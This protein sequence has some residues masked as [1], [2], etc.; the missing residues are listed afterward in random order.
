[1]SRL[2]HT[3]RAILNLAGVDPTALAN[4]VRKLPPVRTLQDR[5]TALRLVDPAYRKRTLETIVAAQNPEIEQPKKPGVLRIATIWEG[6]GRFGWLDHANKDSDCELIH[7]PRSFVNPAWRLFLSEYLEESREEMRLGEY[8]LERYFKAAFLEPRQKFR[9]YCALAMTEAIDAYELDC[10]IMPKLTDD[11]TI[12]FINAVQQVG[13]PVV[14][15]DREGGVSPK[16]LEMVPAHLRALMEVEFDLL[17]THNEIQRELFL[18]SGLPANKILV[19]GA[20][21]SDYWFRPETW[22]TRAEIHPQLRDDRFTIVFFSFGPRTYMNFY[23]GT[24]TRDWN[25]LCRDYHDV[26]LDVLRQYGDRVQIIYKFGGKPARDLFEGY[27]D[28][29]ARAENYITPDNFI[30]LDGTFNSLDLIRNADLILGFQTTGLIEAMFTDNPVVY[31]AWGPLFDDIHE[32]LLPLDQDE[33]LIYA[34]SKEALAQS[35]H[36]LIESPDSFVCTDTMRTARVALRERYFARADGQVSRRL[37]DHAKDI[38]QR[39]RT[40][41]STSSDNRILSVDT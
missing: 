34:N 23:Y 2:K 18:R 21:Q 9:D 7:L 8:A 35:M 28:F 38:A 37:L 6:S 19:N 39:R 15:D 3:A 33:A 24:E 30:E 10:L 27:A 41:L 11:W 40:S 1:M 14:V 31:G 13:L 26:I 12:D 5:R 36:H 22:Q 4:R 29:K 16:R 20:P 17:V 25:P 32:T